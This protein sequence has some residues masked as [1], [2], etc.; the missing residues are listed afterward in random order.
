LKQ[1][2]CLLI[3]LT[4]VYVANKSQNKVVN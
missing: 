4:G 1:I 3:I 2:A